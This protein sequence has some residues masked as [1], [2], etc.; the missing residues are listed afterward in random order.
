MDVRSVTKEYY[1]QLYPYRFDNLDEMDQ[2]C[3]NTICQNS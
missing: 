2:F 1:K 3:E